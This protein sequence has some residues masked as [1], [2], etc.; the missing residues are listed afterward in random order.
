MSNQSRLD[1]ITTTLE[2]GLYTLNGEVAQVLEQVRGANTPSEE[3]LETTL[4][5]CNK[6]LTEWLEMLKD[7]RGELNGKR[8]VGEEE[9]VRQ[10]DEDIEREDEDIEREDEDIREFDNEDEDFKEFD[11]EDDR[12]FEDALTNWDLDS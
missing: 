12:E 8:A 2:S 6:K 1:L 4:V 7:M 11:N 10:E 9:K 3:S 5:Q